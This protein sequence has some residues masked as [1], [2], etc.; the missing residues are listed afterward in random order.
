MRIRIR[1]DGTTADQHRLFVVAFEKVGDHIE[2]FQKTPIRVERSQVAGTF[3]PLQGG[4]RFADVTIGGG[5]QRPYE[6]EVWIEA[7]GA[8]KMPDGLVEVFSPCTR[9][10]INP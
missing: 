3:Q 5:T 8:I 2:A 4:R 7:Q 1:F 6:G 10:C 9:V